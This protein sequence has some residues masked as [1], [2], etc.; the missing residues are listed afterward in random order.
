M[1]RR[2]PPRDISGL[3]LR[4][5]GEGRDLKVK[6]GAAHA[7]LSQEGPFGTNFIDIELTQCLVFFAVKP[8][9]RKT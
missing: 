7:A 3:R 5:A 1:W 6:A 9:P 4:A 2:S 8:S